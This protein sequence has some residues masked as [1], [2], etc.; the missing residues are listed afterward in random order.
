MQF[1]GSTVHD[2]VW[3]RSRAER[4]RAAQFR[5][6]HFRAARTCGAELSNATDEKDVH[7]ILRLFLIRKIIRL[8]LLNPSSNAR[9]LHPTFTVTSK[10]P[11]HV[12]QL[13]IILLNV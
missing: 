1:I 13:D 11:H 8:V 10:T 4:F 6:A 12:T 9:S 5:A 2:T 7:L 3:S